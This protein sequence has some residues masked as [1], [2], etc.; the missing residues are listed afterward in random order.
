MKKL[1]F[2]VLAALLIA[3][4]A[5][6][7]WWQTFGGTEKDEGRC[8]QQTLDGGYIVTGY[9]VSFGTPGVADIW[10][11]KLNSLGHTEWTKTY[12]TGGGYSVRE[13]SDGGYIIAGSR[14]I[15][16]DVNGDTIWTRNFEAEARCVQITN[17]G[18]YVVTGKKSDNLWLIKIDD[19]GD[20]LWSKMYRK[21]SY[22]DYGEYIEQT[23]DGG[24]I[25]VGKTGTVDQENERFKSSLWLLKTDAEGDTVWTKTYGGDE[26]DQWDRGHCVRQTGDGGYILTG[27]VRGATLLKTDSQGDTLWIKEYGNAIGR[28]VEQTP[29]GGFIIAG[30]ISTYSTLSFLSTWDN[31]WLVKTDA[32]GDTTW[33]R[34]YGDGSGDRG[35]YVQQTT[36]DGYIVVGETY[37]FGA[38]NSDLYLLKTDSLGL[39]AIDEGPQPKKGK[40]WQ[41]VPAIGSQVLLT[42]W[43]SP[44][45]FR[46][47]VFDVS[48]R[49]TDVLEST[50]ASGILS[51]GN[52]YPA[53]VYFIHA[54][55]AQKA[56]NTVRIIIIR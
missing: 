5:H 44:Q 46:A 25:I 4:T 40:N 2:I 30:S 48:G 13:T 32:N 39:L 55:D 21:G 31:L 52:G 54:P 28:C 42:Y 50:G 22:A 23:S 14:L 17:D 11:I 36:D 10:L 15:K 8:V 51:W 26:W 56:N 37:S 45:G 47:E 53:G 9:T 41:V 38:G 33:T 16:T 34:D 35:Y 49:K 24:Y 1:A 43:D 20:S 18:N 3:T 12:E 7:G 6:A 29:D 27:T 19:E